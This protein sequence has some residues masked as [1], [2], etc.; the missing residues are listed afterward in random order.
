MENPGKKNSLKLFSNL[1]YNI[2]NNNDSSNE[3][4]TTADSIDNLFKKYDEHKSKNRKHKKQESTHFKNYK[5]VTKLTKKEEKQERDTIKIK[6]ATLADKLYRKN[7]I[8]KS[9]HNKLYNLSIGASRL[10]TLITAYENL[11]GFKH[12]ESTVKKSNYTQSLKEK[13][14]SKKAFN[15]VYIKYEQFEEH[16]G[17][18]TSKT[19]NHTF[20]MTGDENDIRREIKKFIAY[21]LT[22]PYVLKVEI[23]R[24]SINK[25]DKEN[26]FYRWK[27]GKKTDDGIKY[28]KAWKSHF[29]YHGFKVDMN[30]ETQFECVP[31]ALYKMY[32][33]REAGRSKFI[34]GVADKGI[35]YIKSILDEYDNVHN[36]N[37]DNED[38]NIPKGYTPLHILYFCNK[39]KIPCYG[40]NYKMEKFITNSDKDND[41]KFNYNLPA[42]AFYFNDNHIYLINDKQMRHALLTNG[43][44]SDI[45]SL[46]SKERKIEDKAPKEIKVD[47]PFDDWKTVENTN[48]FITVPRLVHDT[49]YKLI[50][51]GDIYN[52]KVKINE[53]EGI[54]KFKYENKNTI[55]YNPDYHIVNKTIATLNARDTQQ[56]YEFKNQRLQTLACEYFDNEFGGLPKSSMNESGDKLFHSEFIRNCQFNGWFQKPTSDDLTACDFN[57]HYTSNLMGEDLK[58]GWSVFNVFDEIEPFDGTIKTGYYYVETDN[59]FPFRG[60]GAYDADLIQGGLD[61]HIIKLSQ[62]KYRYIPSVVL[63]IDY[64]K[65]F[66]ES[67]YKNFENPKAAINGFIGLMGHDFNNKNKHIF[68]SNS[69]FH[70]KERASNPNIQTKYLYEKEFNNEES[71]KPIDINNIMISDFFYDEKPVCYHMYD[72]KRVKHFQNDLPIFYKIYNVS[73]LKMYRLYKKLGGKLLGVF[74]DT[75]ICEGKVNKIEYNKDIIGGIRETNV[76]EFTQL[77]NKDARSKKYKPETIKLTKINEY[78]IKKGKGVF[79]EGEAGTGKTTLA[80]KLKASL[81]PHQYKIATPTHKSSLL[82][83]DA[84]TIYSLFNINQHNHTYLKSTVDKLK[85]EGVE[86][87]FIDEISMISSKVWAALRDI[88]KI[89]QFKFILIGDFSQ[90]DSIESVHYDVKNS[91]VFAELVDCQMLELTRNWR[92]ENDPKFADFISDLR[93][94]RDGGKPNFSTYDNKEC[95]KSICWTNR[96]RK[97]INNKW[98]VK[99]S[100]DKKYIVVNNIKVFVGLPIICKKT[101][102]IDKHDLK[103]NEEFEV[104][105]VDS[106]T[107]EIKNDRLS[108]TIKHDQFKHFDLTYCI[109]THT[110]QGSTYDFPYSIY[111]YRY[112]D[113]KLLYT[114]MS[115]STQKQ[116]INFIDTYL[117]PSKGYIYKIVDVN[118]KHYIGS[119]NTPDKRWTEHCRMV[120][121]S[122]LHRSMKLM[123]LDKFKFEVIDEV[124]YIDIE[125]LLIKESVYMNEYNSIEAG[126]NTKH[127]VDLQNIY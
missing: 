28:M 18:T 120:E 115:R 93:I 105:N 104:I 15:T 96:T 60:N 124:E 109:T 101:M 94:V 112:F 114:A 24:L 55:I 76:K 3:W 63:P 73:A 37:S 58:F 32:G 108:C 118:G 44:K 119:T 56:K 14:E 122:P 67:V 17:I 66:I 34:A 31:N 89:Y 64:F 61:E 27:G 91:S 71:E 46:L 11:K 52:G 22:L 100:K 30:D 92:A 116:N 53:K 51:Q 43:N 2:M 70:F 21:V 78:D 19:L 29:K 16:N 7:K 75:V 74:T 38:N 99:E 45:I 41:I 33:N 20:S 117:K 126:Y 8:T 57:K 10:P 113:K 36:D 90:L 125:T 47:L 87:I 4:K 49:F 9:L 59:F 84:Q 127:S 68:T 1:N 12:T 102:T 48:I 98:M 111:E 77:M 69:E 62:I 65:K 110:A 26:D 86:Y 23:L 13:K 103:N 80:N 40:Y 85:A 79:I 97:L 82:Y 72:M 88:K 95:K 35:E 25:E 107:I 39:Y 5:Q 54:V 42:F 123:G 83:D 50:I 6:I 81:K 121:D 106:K